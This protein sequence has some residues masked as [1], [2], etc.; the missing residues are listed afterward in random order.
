MWSASI[1]SISRLY[2][3][4]ICIYNSIPLPPTHTH[5]MLRSNDPDGFQ[6]M[7][8][9][10][11]DKAIQKDKSGEM[12]Q[13]SMLPWCFCTAHSAAGGFSYDL[14]VS[15]SDCLCEYV[16][17]SECGWVCVC[18]R[19]QY[20]VWMCVLLGL[21]VCLCPCYDAVSVCLSYLWCSV[22]VHDLSVMLCVFLP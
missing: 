21:I 4:S 18:V 3:D 2:L 17:V 19:M 15:V 6:V 20:C 13:P 1:W 14:C 8:R 12:S 16:I 9:Y 11:E 10:F 5:R 7:F 22:C